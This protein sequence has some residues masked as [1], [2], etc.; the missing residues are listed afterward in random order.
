MCD[1]QQQQQQQK[2]CTGT[3]VTAKRRVKQVVG[4]QLVHIRV[5]ACPV[6]SLLCCF[7]SFCAGCMQWSLSPLLALVLALV[8]PCFSG[9]K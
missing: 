2:R 5:P 4:D 1:S 9:H 7:P 6:L 3:S 8:L